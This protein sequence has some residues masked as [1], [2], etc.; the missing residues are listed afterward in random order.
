MTVV[1]PPL[2][3]PLMGALIF[4]AQGFLNLGLTGQGILHAFVAY[5]GVLRIAIMV[6]AV[7]IFVSS[8]DDLLI[9]IAYW[10]R[11]LIRL[12]T[13]WRNQPKQEKL[14]AAPEKLIALMVPAWQEADVIATMV[15]NTVGVFDYNRYK[16]FV[17]VYANDPDTR[18]E[19]EKVRERFPN[20]YRAEVPHEGP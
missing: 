4:F 11:G 20:V 3:P 8:L 10:V 18:R 17:G 2:L 5:W 13:F 7:L 9:D 6:T 19:V 12:A 16:I 1:L 14:E 15:A